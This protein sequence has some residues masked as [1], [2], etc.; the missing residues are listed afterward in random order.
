MDMNVREPWEMHDTI[1]ISN[2][3][4]GAESN[5]GFYTNFVAFGQQQEHLLFKRRS[6]GNVHRAYCNQL[7]EDRSD[8][9]FR[10]FQVGLLFIGPPTPLD[11]DAGTPGDANELAPVWWTTD[12]PRHVA[13]SLR[14]GQDTN[15]VLNGMMMSPGYGPKTSGV[16]YGVDDTAI[17]T[18]WPEMVFTATQ[19][20]PQPSS[21][22][23]IAGGSYQMP[24][25]IGIPKGELIEMRLRVSEYARGLLVQLAGPGAYRIGGTGEA[26]AVSIDTSYAIQA[27]LWGYREVQQR[28]ELRAS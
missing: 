19:G 20:E 26:A 7:A 6:E 1:R 17:G 16:A 27:S 3:L 5:S 8:F 28:G 10:V 22:Y 24:E 23:W 21:R 9:V 4:F 25:P 2:S 11:C 18:N 14:I 15:L 12:F 13:A